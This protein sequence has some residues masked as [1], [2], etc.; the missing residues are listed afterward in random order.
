[1]DIS[2][3]EWLEWLTSQCTKQLLVELNKEHEG[4]IK[5]TAMGNK[6]DFDS[7][8]GKAMEAKF[9]IEQILEKGE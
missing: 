3:E 9:I 5:T 1:M 6:E 8:Q 7:N 4:L 2:K